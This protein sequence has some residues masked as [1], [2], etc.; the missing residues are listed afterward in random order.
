MK[1]C[2][3]LGM[4]HHRSQVAAVRDPAKG[5]HAHRVA[6]VADGEGSLLAGGG[7]ATGAQLKLL[8]SQEGQRRSPVA[9]CKDPG[10]KRRGGNLLRNEV[11]ARGRRS[12]WHVWPGHKAAPL[13]AC[14][15]AWCVLPVGRLLMSLR[16]S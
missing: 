5:H 9:R 8:E 4:L 3:Y 7:Q 12:A 15:R 11:C 16:E 1:G 2:L 13:A 6:A 10:L 14:T